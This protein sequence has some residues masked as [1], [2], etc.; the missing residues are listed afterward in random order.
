MPK[1]YEY[2]NLTEER[3]SRKLEFIN[4][5]YK[6][7]FKFTKMFGLNRYKAPQICIDH[8]LMQRNGQ[9]YLI[10]GRLSYGSGGRA[11]NIW[12]ILQSFVAKIT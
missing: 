4:L 2:S 11:L 1:G 9:K 3:R 12:K 10:G 8:G 5:Y 6:Y 7:V